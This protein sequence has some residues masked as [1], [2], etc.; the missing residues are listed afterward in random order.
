M[1][2]DLRQFLEG[3]VQERSESSFV[4]GH[5]RAAVD[6]TGVRGGVLE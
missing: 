5:V 3:C 4:V 1:F 2:V 6:L